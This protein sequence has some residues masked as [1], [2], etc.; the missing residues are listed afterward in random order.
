M[1]SNDLNDGGF[2][3]LDG[4]SAPGH[5]LRWRTDDFEIALNDRGLLVSLRHP[6]DLRGMDWVSEASPLPWG[7]PVTREGG[8]LVACPPG[9][10][11]RAEARGNTVRF[12]RST[13]HGVLTVRLEQGLRDGR[14]EQRFTWINTTPHPLDLAEGDFGVRV[15]LPDNYPDA[16][17]CMDRRCNVHLWAGG[18]SAWICAL[19][20][21]GEAPHLGLVVTAGAVASYSITDRPWHSHDRG[22]F[23]LHPPSA[24]L[25]PGEAVSV[26]WRVFW[27]AG[28]EDFFQKARATPGFVR[29]R[30]ERYTVTLG[31]VLRVAAEA[32]GPIVGATLSVNGRALPAKVEDAG[33]TL[34][35]EFAPD[36]PGEHLV[37]LAHAGGETW[38][39]AFATPE[40][41]ELIKARVRFL[42][43]HQQVV[44][45][46]EP[47]HGAFLSYDN[48]TRSRAYSTSNDHN[49]G[50]ERVGMGVLLALYLPRCHDA[51]LAARI[52]AS[53]DLHWRFVTTQLQ[54]ESGH[55]YNDVGRRDLDR[56]YNA[57]WVARL[58]LAMHAADPQPRYLDAYVRTMR[59]FYAE[60]GKAF[61]PIG[62][63]VV[64]GLA[65][66]RAAGREGERAELAALLREHAQTLIATG[67][68]MPKS[69]VN[70]EQSIVGPV[71]EVL[72]QLHLGVAEAGDRRYLDAAKEFL[73]PLLAFNGRQPD[74]H[75]HDVAIRHWD[76]YW[77]G[78]RALYGDTFPHYWSTITALVLDYLARA[79]PESASELRERARRIVEN[80]FSLFTPAGE[81]SAAYLYPGSVNDRPGRFA[82]PLANDQDWVLVHHLL[83][84]R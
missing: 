21:G 31:A 68:D 38:L 11:E 9:V 13:I 5:A 46:G 55:V 75:L 59:A 1:M 72:L 40:P 44:A 58:H 15:P 30:A 66:L 47:L 79:E 67:R 41:L 52:R 22:V 35:A 34:T 10:V 61:Y 2:P 43:E 24:R 63:P 81:A 56:L 71:C 32:A 74:H 37:R 27:H 28:W 17:T 3:V 78:K 84:T 73:A 7:V 16:A 70:Y 29:L 45:P 57:P 4:V 19:R 23:V 12:E 39:R 48:E 53:L 25:L 49:A 77:F 26:A 80:N 18:A 36:A 50:R 60:G 51:A 65:A 83:I 6:R 82:D 8:R 76:G 54:D 69:E 33:R 64:D 62:L 20:M 14:L 42:I